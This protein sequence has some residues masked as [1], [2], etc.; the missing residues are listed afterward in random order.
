[1]FSFV[2]SVTMSRNV[3]LP[4]YPFVDAR[5]RAM[6]LLPRVEP[7]AQSYASCLQHM[8]ALCS[9]ER[10]LVHTSLTIK[11]SAPSQVTENLKAF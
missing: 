8:L 10:L 6:V 7:P 3:D 5:C 2:G 4:V 9:Y 1:M 11:G